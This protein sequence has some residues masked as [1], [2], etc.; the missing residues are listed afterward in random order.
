MN[1][2]AERDAHGSDRH[3]VAAHRIARET[4]AFAE[5]D[6]YIRFL[7]ALNVNIEPS[8]W[9]MN[10]LLPTTTVGAHYTVHPSDYIRLELGYYYNNTP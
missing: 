2:I 10:P 4:A 9:I 8:D 3:E 5:R 6:I 7:T 1:V